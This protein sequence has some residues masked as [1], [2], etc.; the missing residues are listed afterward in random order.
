MALVLHETNKKRIFE[1][2]GLLV[3]YIRN[4]DYKNILI[5]KQDLSGC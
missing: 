2:N 5:S 4:I 1:L 3:D